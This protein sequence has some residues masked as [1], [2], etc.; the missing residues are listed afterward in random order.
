MAIQRPGIATWEELRQAQPKG[1]AGAGRWSASISVLTSPMQL[2]TLSPSTSAW[3]KPT[4]PQAALPN[5][6]GDTPA[7]LRMGSA[8][9]EPTV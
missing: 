1:S 7:L 5:T 6:C 2:V 8:R 9:E 3:T 4:V